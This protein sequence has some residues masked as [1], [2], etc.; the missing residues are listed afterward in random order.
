MSDD[1]PPLIPE[2]PPPMTKLDW[3]DD[4]DFMDL[5]HLALEMPSESSLS[6][7]GGWNPIDE[8]SLPYDGNA[9]DEPGGCIKLNTSPSDWSSDIVKTDQSFNST[10][11]EQQPSLNQDN[12]SIWKDKENIVPQ[13]NIK[14]LTSTHS[15]DSINEIDCKPEI[16]YNVSSENVIDSKKK[17]NDDDLC[18]TIEQH[19]SDVENTKINST[20]QNLPNLELQIINQEV[21]ENNE[22]IQPDIVISEKFSSISSSHQETLV[23]GHL[24]N[25]N[26]KK[27]SNQSNSVQNIL[28]DNLIIDPSDND[29]KVN[30]SSGV[31]EIYNNDLSIKNNN[32]NSIIMKIDQEEYTDFCDYETSS[33]NVMNLPLPD[34]TSKEV[35]ENCPN[36]EEKI[37]NKQFNDEQADVSHDISIFNEKIEQNVEPINTKSTL[38][39]LENNIINS[40]QNF[41]SEF[42]EFS[43]FHTFS[44][45]TT[46]KKPIS[47]TDNDDFCDFETNAPSFKNTIISEN[48]KFLTSNDNIDSIF[49]SDNQNIVNHNDNIDDNFCDFESGYSGSDFNT[50][51]QV[52]D[53]KQNY[54][55]KSEFLIQ[56]DYKEFCKDAFQ[57]DYELSDEVD[58]QNLDHELDESQVWQNLKDIESSPAL[59]YNWLKSESNSVFLSSLSIDSRNILYGASWN[60][61]MPRFAAN[62][63]NNPLEPLK[64]SNNDAT[65]TKISQSFSNSPL[66][67]TVPD[68]EFDWKSSGLINPLDFQP[69]TWK[70]SEVVKEEGTPVQSSPESVDVFD[71]FFNSSLA[72][73]SDNQSI[74]TIESPSTS[75]ATVSLEAQRILDNLPNFDVLEKPYLAILEKESNNFFF[76]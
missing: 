28:L 8:L 4:E 42:D 70:T 24:E 6:P 64:A 29:T 57:G 59:N 44:I 53:V 60:P 54:V 66:Q 39:N 19:T 23:N 56:L 5:P 35:T 48:S 50:S 55:P 65:D 15:C 38:K 36:I 11:S 75:V 14:K 47:T 1:I 61:K 73:S 51:R 17:V 52:L 30:S 10:L 71:Q 7:D 13:E 67:D 43:D 37:I 68:P 41:D 2:T 16:K 72:S 62:M 21:V 32:N 18:E 12:P 69:Q 74:E 20:L 26:I 3:E 31:F 49:K 9:I 46:E 27:L 33:S 25:V 58:L 34:R 63:S 76:N 22:S 40:D 45:S